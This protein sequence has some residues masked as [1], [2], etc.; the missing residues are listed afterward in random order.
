MQGQKAYIASELKRYHRS[1]K[2]LERLKL[3]IMLEAPEQD[4][5][6]SGETN[7]VSRP[8]ENAVL[9]IRQ[10]K[11]V[12]YLE[13]MIDAIEFV[14]DGLGAEKRELVKLKYWQRPVLL[15]DNGIARQLCVSKATVWRWSHEI[16]FDIATEIG[17]IER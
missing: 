14:I 4:D 9:R 17:F 1:K 11:R 3:D 8:V 13:R 2:E 10:N 5:V 7:K 6:K 16:L 12:Q 15:T